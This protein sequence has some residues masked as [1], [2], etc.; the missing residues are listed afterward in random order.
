[1]NSENRKQE[2]HLSKLRRYEF[3]KIKHFFNSNDKVLEIGGGS[4]FQASL[5]SKCVDE[6]V[7]I[8]VYSHP[9]PVSEVKVYDGI[10]IPFPDKYFSAVFSSNALE[11]I[12]D[13]DGMMF[14]L[15]RVLK[16]N[17]VSA[18]IVPTVSWRVF[19]SLAHYPGIPRLLWSNYQNL[20]A[21]IA[22][23]V[24][25]KAPAPEIRDDP[26]SLFLGSID[27]RWISNIF[28]HFKLKWIKSILLSPRHGERGNAL[29]EAWFYRSKW[30]RSKFAENGMVIE[31]EFSL[32]LFYTGNTVFGGVLSLSIRRFLSKIFGSSTRVFLVKYNDR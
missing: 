11:H 5:I 1:M 27:I 6:I 18:H 9:I 26:T 14:E 7:S 30:W 20:K 16:D 32:G 15:K 12:Q 4:G 24:V 3:G 25:T 10:N 23:P 17:G 29:T 13:I 8:D 19:T 28:T 21:K 2:D 22:P 31:N